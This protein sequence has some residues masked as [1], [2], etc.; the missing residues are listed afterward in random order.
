M[1]SLP[2]PL[3]ALLLKRLLRLLAFFSRVPS[4]VEVTSMFWTRERGESNCFF[5]W[6]ASLLWAR[7][8]WMGVDW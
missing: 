4:C 8:F 5:F 7:S 2:A 1:K 3:L 6:R